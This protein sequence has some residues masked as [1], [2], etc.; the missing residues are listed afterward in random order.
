GTLFGEHKQFGLRINAAHEDI[1]SYVNNGDGWRDFASLSASWALSSKTL[2]QFDA[3]YQQK[4][5]HSVAGYQ[6]LGGT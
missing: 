2:V 1:H 5:Q 6:L 4:A 3:E